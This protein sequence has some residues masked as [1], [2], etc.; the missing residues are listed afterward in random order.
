MEADLLQLA[1]ERDREEERKKLDARRMMLHDVYQTNKKN[2]IVKKLHMKQSLEADKFENERNAFI[3]RQKEAERL[4]VEQ[5]RR[6]MVDDTG[7]QNR[8]LAG[9]VKRRELEKHMEEKRKLINDTK[10]PDAHVYN[11][12]DHYSKVLGHKAERA[13][14]YRQGKVKFEDDE[15]DFKLRMAGEKKLLDHDAVGK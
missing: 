12:Q 3:A 11:A 6:E 15:K 9:E 8:A 1:M 4:Q 13:D 2:Q 10:Y 5:R 7:Y 14:A